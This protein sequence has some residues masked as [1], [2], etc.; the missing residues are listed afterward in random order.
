ME[1][2]ELVKE[3]NG[4]VSIAGCKLGDKPPLFFDNILHYSVDCK[5]LGQNLI[6]CFIDVDTMLINNPLRNADI[7]DVEI[8][9][10]YKKGKGIRGLY[11]YMRNFCTFPYKTQ[12]EFE[13]LAIK[14]AVSRRFNVFCPE[15]NPKYNYEMIRLENKKCEVEFVWSKIGQ[16]D[17]TYFIEVNVTPPICKEDN[18]F[19]TEAAFIKAQRRCVLKY[20]KRAENFSEYEKREFK[21]TV[22]RITLDFFNKVWGDR[23]TKTSVEY[24][25]E[26]LIEAGQMRASDWDVIYRRAGMSNYEIE[27]YRKAQ[28]SFETALNDSL[29]MY[30]D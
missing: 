1:C 17:K 12:K 13:D 4:I 19:D 10:R 20:G 28:E 2:I 6:R 5:S 3:E 25:K 30:R 29:D 18:T 16:T 15:I 22:A 9:C 24:R 8:N 23:I 11:L 7:T 26:N 14:L 27:Q 21:E